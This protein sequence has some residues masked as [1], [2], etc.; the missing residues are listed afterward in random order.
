MKAGCRKGRS[1]EHTKAASA[2]SDRAASPTAIPCNGPSPSRGSEA[3]STSGG[4]SG[5]C[6][7]G[8]RTTITGPVTARATTE[9]VRRSRV[10]PCQSRAALGEPMREERPPAS[11][12]PAVFSTTVVMRIAPSPLGIVQ[13]TARSE[14]GP[15]RLPVARL[16]AVVCRC[17]VQPRLLP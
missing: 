4:R 6:W 9:T 2:R 3:T 10:E 11:T 16:A 8:A 15:G 14:T 12:T 5:S 17:W 13:R 1:V 7:P